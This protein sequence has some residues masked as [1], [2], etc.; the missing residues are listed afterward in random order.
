[1]MAS[2]LYELGLLAERDGEWKEAESLLDRSV[3]L[4]SESEHEFVGQAQD[5]LERIRRRA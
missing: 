2:N 3:A 5:A 4:F 1:L